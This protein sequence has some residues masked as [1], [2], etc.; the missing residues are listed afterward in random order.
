MSDEIYVKYKG[1]GEFITGVPTK[2]M[3]KERWERI[4]DG[5]RALAIREGLF[6]LIEKK[7][8]AKEEV[9]EEVEE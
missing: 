4:P 1:K 7:S 5:L 3:T 8:K 9:E 6:E 2:D